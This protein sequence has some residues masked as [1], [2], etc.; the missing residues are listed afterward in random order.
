MSATVLDRLVERLQEALQYNANVYAAPIA[1]LWP[2]ESRHWIPAIPRIAERLPVI[3]LGSFDPDA[4]QGPAYWIRCMVAGKLNRERSAGIPVVYLPGVGRNALRAVE[5]CPSSLAP[6]AELQYRSE[7]FSHLNGRDWSLWALLTNAERGIGL[8]IT[9][10]GSTATALQLALEKF[11]DEPVA[12]IEHLVLDADFFHDLVNPDPIR[13]LLGWLDD[14]ITFQSRYDEATWAAFVQQCK[15]DFGFDPTRDGAIVAA[16]KLAERQGKLA[17]AWRRFAETPE[18]YPGIPDQLRKARPNDQL[19]IGESVEL[20]VWP[21][22]NEA[23]EDQLRSALRDFSILTPE[24]A[25]KEVAHLEGE[26]SWRR[27]T[28]WADLNRARLAFGLEQLVALAEVTSQP[29]AAG[30]LTELTKDYVARGW[31]ADEAFVRALESVPHGSDREAVAAAAT[32]IYRSWLEVGAKSLQSIV[33]PMANSHTYL[34]GPTIAK[35]REVVT[36]FVDG[37]RIDL[38]RRV[39]ARLIGVGLDVNETTHLAALPTVTQTAKAALVPVQD[40]SLKAGPDLHPANATSG[41][42]ASTEVL[43]TLMSSGGVQVLSATDSGDPSG[44]AWAEVGEIDHRGHDVGSRVVDYLDEDIDRIVG[45]I[46]ELIDAG[47]KRVDL[48]TDHGWLLLPGGLEKVDLPPAA[49]EVKKGRCAR[50]KHGA[51]VEVP[52]VP[53]YWDQDV[54]IAIA[55]GATC[56]EAGKEY[57]HGGVSPQECIVLKLSISAGAETVTAGPEVTSIKWLGL[58][59]RVE[60]SGATSGVRADL[61]GEPANSKTSIAQESKE[62]AGA[63]RLTLVVP[64]EEL[65][66]QPAYF[67]LVGAEGEILFQREVV[68]GRNL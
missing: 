53:W 28:V 1:L 21:Q 46:R 40:G 65:E 64:D 45:R 7:W 3:T 58:L 49:T 24:G 5:S 51:S 66:G 63:G 39:Q 9:D 41:T 33:G 11:L 19:I 14:P 17:E 26:H 18:R 12:Q 67:V 38:A 47:W 22:D 62:T 59:C 29:L 48:V 8:R 15:S 43:R 16:R 27:G 50:L 6:I 52:T 36:L 68:V 4:N 2:D 34:A 55:P 25:R 37:L 35:E 20:G 60:I 31:R 61:R 30:N 32:A 42:R 10:G 54:R 44:A 56:F 13:S 57:E 23:A